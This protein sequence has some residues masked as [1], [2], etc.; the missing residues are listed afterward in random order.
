MKLYF[1]PLACSLATRICLYEAHA[2]VSFEQVDLETKLTSAGHDYRAV[3]PLGLVPVLELDDGRRLSENAA[4][5]QYVARR[6]PAAALAPTDP[7]EMTELQQ[8][9]SFIGSELH[10]ALFAPL[11]LKDGSP[12]ARRFALSLAGPRLDWL[13]RQLTDRAYLLPRFTVADAYAFVVLNW[14]Q[15]TPIDLTVWPAL[16]AYVARI[17]TR[18]SV[19]RALEEELRLYR[20]RPVIGGVTQK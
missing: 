18:P 14:S 13:A 12:E 11:L 3:S 9:L 2:A 1:S 10:K 17:Q 19:A 8:W 16:L 5:L 7:E 6:F 20:A 15:A 4:V